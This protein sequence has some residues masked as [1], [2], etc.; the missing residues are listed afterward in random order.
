MIDLKAPVPPP[1]PATSDG[2]KPPWTP[3]AAA[4]EIADAAQR[5][6]DE[7]QAWADTQVPPWASRGWP[8]QKAG[9]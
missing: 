8:R 9:R 7:A 5:S 1:P 4:Q 2:E 6:F 3:E